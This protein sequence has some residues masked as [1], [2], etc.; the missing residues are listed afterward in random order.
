M[1]ANAERVR[2]STSGI[3]FPES[4][5]TTP[6]AARGGAEL[7]DAGL[8]TS[9]AASRCSRNPDCAALAAPT[10]LLMPVHRFVRVD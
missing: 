2:R 7:K 10:V 4:P 1:G 6:A 3:Q 8:G 9:G 5:L